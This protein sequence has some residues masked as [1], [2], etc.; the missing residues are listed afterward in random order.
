MWVYHPLASRRLA[1]VTADAGVELIAWTVDDAER[2]RE[3]GRAR[4][5]RDLLQRPAPVRGDGAGGGRAATQAAP[6][7]PGVRATPA[8]SK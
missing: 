5:E 4:R 8:A 6:A 1:R 7:K 3:P 2:M